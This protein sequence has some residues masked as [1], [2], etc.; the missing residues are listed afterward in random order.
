[1]VFSSCHSNTL[2]SLVTGTCSAD[3]VPAVVLVDGVISKAEGDEIIRTARPLMKE[4]VV[5]G[6]GAVS[7]AQSC[8]LICA[9]D[10]VPESVD[11]ATASVS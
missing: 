1:M 5:S 8:P 11:H 9:T 4:A 3:Q 2:Q 6:D 10:Y 7:T